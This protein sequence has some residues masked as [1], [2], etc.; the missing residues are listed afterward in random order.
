MYKLVNTKRSSRNEQE[1]KWYIHLLDQSNPLKLRMKQLIWT[2]TEVQ[3]S[4]RLESCLTGTILFAMN[5]SD[6]QAWA[7][8][9]SSTSHPELSC[10]TNCCC[11]FNQNSFR[12]LQIYIHASQKFPRTTLN[13]SSRFLQSPY[14]QIPPYWWSH[15]ILVWRKDKRFP[16]LP[17]P[18]LSWNKLERSIMWSW[19][20]IE[21]VSS[22]LLPKVKFKSRW[23]ASSSV[24]KV[25]KSHWC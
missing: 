12:V 15:K 21:E 16:V 5:F 4:Q 18:D 19:R 6:K 10:L 9:Y 24:I 20:R 1:W 23:I 13:W 8:K 11:R 22:F 2:T 25:A 17:S 7:R 14:Y 3:R